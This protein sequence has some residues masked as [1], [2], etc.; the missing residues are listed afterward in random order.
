MSRQKLPYMSV[1][2]CVYNGATLVGRA[3]ESLLAQDYPRDRYEI[4]V[5]DDGSTDA[6]AEIVAGYPVKLVKHPRNL[7]L[8]P[9]RNTG[10]EHARGDVYVGFDDDCV[11]E[12]GWLRT[13]ANAYDRP[14]LAGVASVLVPPA[15]SY[16]LANRFMAAVG[17]GNAPKIN[18]KKTLSPLGRFWAYMRD[19]FAGP[20]SLE[21]TCLPYQTQEIYGASSSFPMEVLKAVGGWDASLHWMEDTDICRRIRGR[22]PNR[23]F[24]AVP[25]ARIVFDDRDMSLRAFATRPYRRGKFNLYYYRQMGLTPP[26]FPFPMLWL[27]TSFTLFTMSAPVGLLAAVV[28]PQLLYAWWPARAV[29]QRDVWNFVFP[30]L[31]LTEELSTVAGLAKG[32]IFTIGDQNDELA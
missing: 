31:Q 11:A 27:S 15:V 1:V 14:G 4:I 9:A 32:W 30:Y 10:L 28:L 3:I 21:G 17:S 13:L 2:L 25:L 6:S 8:A 29:R 24:W 7:G 12:S 16:G 19:Q 26:L 22:F 5:V 23:T 20:T 18:A